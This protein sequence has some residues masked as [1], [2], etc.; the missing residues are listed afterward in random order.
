MSCPTIDFEQIETVVAT[1]YAVLDKSVVFVIGQGTVIETPL[2]PD[3]LVFFK[4]YENTT[5]VFLLCG[6]AKYTYIG[7]CEL[8]LVAF[9]LHSGRIITETC[10][11]DFLN[12][13][14]RYGASSLGPL[15]DPYISL[16]IENK[17]YS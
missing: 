13:F 14:V 12:H 8:E 10:K 4:M 5:R 15:E 3:L 6:I 7:D 1:V 17:T 16:F 9:Q 11:K 2:P